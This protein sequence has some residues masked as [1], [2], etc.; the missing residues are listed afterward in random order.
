[1]TRRIAS[2]LLLGLAVT[3]GT[4]SAAAEEMNVD[5]LLD[6]LEQQLQLSQERYEA[7][8]PELRAQ[9]EQKSR[10]LSRTLDTALE[11]GLNEL[12]KLGQEYEAA[13][14]ASSE[15]LR[16]YLESEEMV[17]LKEYLAGLD[18]QA[19]EQARDELVADFARLLELSTEQLEALKP[20][21]L[22]K[23][24]KLGD[25]LRRYVDQGRD[26]FEQF[27]VEFEAERERNSEAIREILDSRQMQT[28]EAALD[29]MRE[30]IRTEI[31]EA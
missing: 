26:D 15:K 7:L 18:R 21:L 11:Q 22:E 10:E 3:L 28:F 14:R 27:R 19:L 23:L 6:S 9:L 30:A 12:E 24:E 16:E 13:S 8:K 29:S 4:S 25:I 2:V 17:E 20:L 5:S 31:F 1:M